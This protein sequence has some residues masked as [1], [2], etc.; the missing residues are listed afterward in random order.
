V[1]AFTT[2]ILVNPPLTVTGGLPA[3]VN[4]SQNLPIAWTGGG[5]DVVV[6][7][8]TSAVLISGSTTGNNAVYNAAVFTC[9]TTADKGS[10]S[11]PSSILLQL[12]ATPA[13][14]ATNGTGFSSLSV[15]TSSTPGPNNG[16]FTAPLR[17]GG[18]IDLGL[19]VAG[20]GTLGNP[21][22]Q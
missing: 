4:R 21:T 16:L 2:S 14:A 13:N 20:I 12:P 7:S 5:T 18:S 3:T 6:I 22:Y 10:F 17:T 11:V 8:G 1:G 15:L 9:R 19:F